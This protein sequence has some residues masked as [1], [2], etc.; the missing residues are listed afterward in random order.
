M[1][2]SRYLLPSDSQLFHDIFGTSLI[3]IAVEDVDGN[4]LFANPAFCSFLDF[5][6]KELQRK[7]CVDLSPPEDAAKDWAF[8]QQLRS[9]AI[10]NY[11]LEKRYFRRDGS[12]VWAQLSVSLFKGH[13]SPLV[14]VMVEDIT[15]KKRAE[16]ARFR[17]AAIVESSEDAII[18]KT[19]DGSI[20]GWNTGAQEIFGY[21]EAEAIGKPITIII[22][23]D[24]QHEEQKILER[25]RAGERIQHYETIR[26][27]KAGNRINV[28]LSISPI[29]DS[30]GKVVGASKIARD[31]TEHKRA[32]E[33]MRKMNRD[34]EEKNAL[35]PAREELLR[36][37]VK[38]VP[39]AVAM[40]DREMRYLQVSDRWCT[41]YLHG[42]TQVLGRSHYEIF[43]DMPER[44]KQ[45]HRRALQGETLRA[46]E[47]RWDGEDG[48]HWARWEVRPWNTPEG[49]VGGILIL[50]EDISLRKQMEETLSGM[51]RKLIQS[52]EEERA[53]I[54][55]ELHDDIAQRI[56]LLS[57]TV[58]RL[59]ERIPESLPDVKVPMDEL[60]KHLRDVSSDVQA[61]SHEL[62]SSTLEIL[63]LVKASR[64]WCDQF[65]ERH[66]ME[67]S[68]RTHNISIDL[69]KE[70]SLCLFRILQEGLSNAAKHSS[71]NRV[72]VKLWG[73]SAEIH[74]TI[75]D[76]GKG[77]NVAAARQGGGLGLTSIQER[78]RLV[79]GTIQIDS[80]PF[81]GT[82]I[83]ARV[84]VGE[85]YTAQQAIG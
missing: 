77:F 46:E 3:G 10:D 53:R 75:S 81:R 57:V 43:P 69:S 74:L 44:W 21:K 52:Q 70:I 47:D 33:T 67:I 64:S 80:N 48:T 82:T 1:T 68:F 38:N 28:S 42:K 60:R 37:F 12:L 41:D 59:Q 20:T 15:G 49:N 23:P 30:V 22:P 54:A 26:V 56:A 5:T 7:Y 27:T 29:K 17:H 25:L 8:L 31:I 55:R 4:L 79:S 71:A 32:E 83:H 51:G 2:K 84:P 73:E 34:L 35:L 78:V 85:R 62:H 36:V 76:R 18:S 11:Q 72:D 39:A 14:V 16:E 50:A 63:G 58:D 13:P 45:V 61:V 6:E 65:G 40:L 19:L 24:L 9:G 66:G